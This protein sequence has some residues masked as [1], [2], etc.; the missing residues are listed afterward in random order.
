MTFVSYFLNTTVA[1]SVDPSLIGYVFLAGSNATATAVTNTPSP[2]WNPALQYDSKGGLY[3][4][5][6]QSSSFTNDL[7]RFN[8]VTKTFQFIDGS[9]STGDTARILNK[10]APRRSHASA[11]DNLGNLFVYGG[12]GVSEAGT[13]YAEGFLSDAW[14]WNVTTNAWRFLGGSKLL[15]NPSGTHP[16][17]RNSPSAWVDAFDNSLYVFGGRLLD[18]TLCKS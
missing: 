8:L 11:V 3:V 14:V 5:G 4:F 12:D 7:W 10:P 6:G 9:N 2:R 15:N 16:G 1:Q 18:G 17:A 13:T